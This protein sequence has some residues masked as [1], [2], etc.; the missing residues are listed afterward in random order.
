MNPDVRDEDSSGKAGWDPVEIWREHKD[1]K[2]VRQ[3]L[4]FRAD[5]VRRMQEEWLG[6]GGRLPFVP[7]RNWMWC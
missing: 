6:D 3:F 1:A 5:L 7:I 4:D 2:S